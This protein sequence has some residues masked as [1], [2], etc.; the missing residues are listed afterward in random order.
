MGKI[1]FGRTRE[2]FLESARWAQCAAYLGL[3]TK[4]VQYTAVREDGDSY[5]G[6][7]FRTFYALDDGT[8]V[9]RLTSKGFA[10][11]TAQE[12]A[13]VLALRPS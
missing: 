2:E 10:Q 13:E 12:T 4:R 9:K 5:S 8:V 6:I 11:A 7:F 3:D 1:K